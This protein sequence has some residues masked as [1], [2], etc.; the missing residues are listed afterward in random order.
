MW[1]SFFLNIK[2][3]IYVD[4]VIENFYFM[5]VGIKVFIWM[6]IKNGFMV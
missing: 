6:W 5:I 3:Y 4:V 2:F 1:G